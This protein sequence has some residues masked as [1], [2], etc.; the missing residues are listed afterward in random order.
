MHGQQN[1]KKKKLMTED[2]MAHWRLLRQIKII[3]NTAFSHFLKIE[4]KSR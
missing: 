4:S 2:A 1:I 3:W